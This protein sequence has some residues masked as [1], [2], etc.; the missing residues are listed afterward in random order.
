M[1]LT[2][3]LGINLVNYEEHNKISQPNKSIHR[4]YHTN[5]ILTLIGLR[6][7]FCQK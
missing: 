4:P 2:Y 3:K 6:K 5:F 1:Y 7:K